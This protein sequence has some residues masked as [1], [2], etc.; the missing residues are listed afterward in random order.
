MHLLLNLLR[1]EENNVVI[2]D[3]SNVIDADLD[4]KVLV[5]SQPLEGDRTYTVEYNRLVIATG[6]RV[7]R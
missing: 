3:S 1:Y 6:T 2:L 7:S 4:N 5:V